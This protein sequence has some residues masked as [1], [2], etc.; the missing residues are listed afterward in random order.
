MTY[1][2]IILEEKEWDN[3][4]KKKTDWLVSQICIYVNQKASFTML[5]QT[6][7]ILWK[8]VTDYKQ[9]KIEKLLEVV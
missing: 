5:Y 3:Y 6:T 7:L 4:D 1:K 8:Q 9:K 2:K